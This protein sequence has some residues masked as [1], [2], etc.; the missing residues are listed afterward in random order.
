MELIQRGLRDQG[1]Q[2]YNLVN[3][4]RSTWEELNSV[5]HR[6]LAGKDEKQI[7]LVDYP[8]WVR[9]LG[10]LRQRV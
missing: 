3:P 9:G 5:V 6:G 4:S 8:E 10:E 1:S 2:V 7:K